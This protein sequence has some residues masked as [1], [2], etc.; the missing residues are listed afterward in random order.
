[1]FEVRLTA[2]ASAQIAETRV[3]TLRRF[4]PNKHEQYDQLVAEALA[5]LAMNP[6]TGRRRPDIHP[7][8]LLRRSPAEWSATERP[9]R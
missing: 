4:G 5:V 8:D 6:E 9:S 2:T 3:Y 7:M 1:V